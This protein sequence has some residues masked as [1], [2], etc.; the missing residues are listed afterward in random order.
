MTSVWGRRGL[1]QRDGMADSLAGIVLAAGAGSR[2]APLTRV[3]P[4]PLCP[5]GDRALL[6]HALDELVAGVGPI[7]VNVHHDAPR[8]LEHIGSTPFGGS[9]HV[10]HEAPE[11]LGTAGAIGNLRGWVDGRDLVVLNA[12]TWIPGT[13]GRAVGE[14]LEGWD[15]ERAAVLTSTPGGFGPHSSVVASVLPRRLVQRISPEPAGLWEVVW[16]GELE[17]GRLQWIH[18]DLR[19]LDCGTPRRYL[20]ANL[21]WALEG[22][23]APGGPAGRGWV[24]PDASVEG[25]VTGSVIGAGAT[26]RGSVRSSVLWPG[27]AVHRGETL[28]HAVRAGR[29]TVLV[30]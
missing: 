3:L 21:L 20:A 12:D 2:L 28:E 17:E 16:R 15:R 9:V 1:N 25:E 22:S 4:K 24:H 29:R 27:A 7:A 10:S 19:A 18:T 5:L 23:A 13:P 26:V 30:R 11:P 8:L 14:L 6:D